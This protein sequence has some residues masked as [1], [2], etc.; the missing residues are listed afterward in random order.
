MGVFD[1]AIWNG[2]QNGALLNTISLS[3]P[4]NW[5]GFHFHPLLFIFVPLY[6]LYP[7]PEWLILAQSLAITSTTQPIYKTA[8]R[9][10]YTDWQA[11]FWSLGFL[12]NPFVLSAAQWDFHPVA[13]ATPL[14][15]WCIYFLLT[16]N[17]S[18]LLLCVVGVLLCQEQFGILIMFLGLSHYFVNKNPKQA[19]FLI[20]IGAFYTFIL[21]YFIFPALSPTGTH[22][23]MSSENKVLS[24][25][26]WLGRNLYEILEH[27]FSSPLEI[28][29]IV[30]VDLK[31][32]IYILF[33][34][35]PYGMLL[36]LIGFEILLI[37][38]TDFAANA[39]SLNPL[40]RSII[41]YHSVTLIPIIL[42]AAMRGF[43]L[44]SQ[45]VSEMKKKRT[46]VLAIFTSCVFLSLCLPHLFGPKSFWQLNL[47]PHKKT[48]LIEIR[49]RLPRQASLSVQA[50]IGPHFSQRESVYIFPQKITEAN[51]I[52]LR[53]EDIDNSLNEDISRFSHY[54]LMEP[55]DYLNTIRCT[56]ESGAYRIGYF[57]PPWLILL[58]AANATTDMQR[59]QLTTYLSQ[60]EKRWKIETHPPTDHVCKWTQ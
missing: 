35:A 27:L 10:N 12:L 15:A 23:M 20:A 37:G 5:L 33:L 42:I 14:I 40:P 59:L 51:A 28:L 22:L 18:K 29:R 19:W 13:I 2:L 4:I 47:I 41:S 55:K 36:P 8:L 11:F 53:M 32:Y 16:N 30:I 60:L 21:F 49:K 50:N 45:T 58:K 39:L 3:I 26:N 38:T 17:F 34:L 6:K 57:N 7:G 46:I 56:L 31:G 54:M 48:E 44:F 1:Q 25:Y 24:R 9:L 52:L 43:K